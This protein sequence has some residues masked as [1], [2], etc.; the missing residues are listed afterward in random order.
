MTFASLCT[1]DTFVPAVQMLLYTFV[2]RGINSFLNNATFSRCFSRFQGSKGCSNLGPIGL[3]SE[4]FRNSLVY[5]KRLLAPWSSQSV[6]ACTAFDNVLYFE[7]YWERSFSYAGTK[8]PCMSVTS[9][10]ILFRPF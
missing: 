4:I 6:V 9:L 8:L 3:S 7:F 5:F 1:W 2:R 10:S